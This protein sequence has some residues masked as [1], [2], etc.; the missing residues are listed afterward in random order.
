MK[1]LLVQPYGN[2]DGHYSMYTWK[3]ERALSSLIDKKITILSFDGFNDNWEKYSNAQ[4]IKA[5]EF[6]KIYYLLIKFLHRIGKTKLLKT[7]NLKKIIYFLQSYIVEKYTVRLI[8]QKKYDVVHFIDF[9]PFTLSIS[10]TLSP[11]TSHLPLSTL[12]N[13]KLK[14]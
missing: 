13:L 7:V 8:N 4:F 14:Y 10:L 2:T 11:V 6:K 3:L 9:D 1:I 5:Q 12:S